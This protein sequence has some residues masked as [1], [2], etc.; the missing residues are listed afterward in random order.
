VP[1]SPATS[2]TGTD[3]GAPSANENGYRYHYMRREEV[4]WPATNC[5]R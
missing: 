2:A 5:G 1:C 3:I 4:R